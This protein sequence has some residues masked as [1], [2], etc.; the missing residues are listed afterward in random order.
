[1]KSKNTD[2]KRLDGL[3][4]RENKLE[5]ELKKLEREEG[6]LEKKL[7]ELEIKEMELA[8]MVSEL[9]HVKKRRPNFLVNYMK[10]RDTGEFIAEITPSSVI[11]TVKRKRG[12]AKKVLKKVLISHLPKK[13]EEK[14]S[15]EETVEGE[16]KQL[17]KAQIKKVLKK[18]KLVKKEEMR[19]E[20]IRE[21]QVPIKELRMDRKIDDSMRLFQVLLSTGT[22]TMGEARKQLNVDKDT[23]KKW[24]KDLEDAGI[25]EV[26]TPL[27]GS[28][29]L[30]LKSLSA[31]IKK[32]LTR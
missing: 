28:P 31:K 32:S 17:L 18:Q 16:R 11:G 19:R 22:M 2:T 26:S 30:K 7:K 27:Y 15:G 23:I 5:K 12:R 9:E 25:I 1:M 10:T 29:K 20:E 24:T 13:I 21:S 4:R 3:E 14:K 8:K 6:V